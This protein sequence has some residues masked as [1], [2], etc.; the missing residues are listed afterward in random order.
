MAEQPRTV[1]VEL[2]N[3]ERMLYSGEA[4]MVVA[5]TLDGEIA[6]MPGHAP[7]LGA[8]LPGR[9]RIL[10]SDGTELVATVHSGFVEVCDN[11]VTILSDA[12]EVVT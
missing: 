4:S 3:P 6:L 10:E 5:R 1:Q 7:L 9:L 8:L 11:R 12:I 2:L